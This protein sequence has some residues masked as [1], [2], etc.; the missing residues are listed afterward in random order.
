MLK[1][2]FFN[3]MHV[4]VD[5]IDIFRET[6]PDYDSELPPIKIPIKPGIYDFSNE[7]YHASTGISCSGLKLI[8]KSPLH[9]WHHY[10]NPNKPVEKDNKNLI[11][12]SALHTLVLE[13][14]L[15]NDRFITVPKIDKRTLKGK[16][17]WK[18]YEN[19]KGR[20]SILLE[21]DFEKI[22]N[23][24]SSIQKAPTIDKLIKGAQYEKSLY[25]RDEE[26][27]AL[28]KARPDILHSSLVCDIK[29]TEDASYHAF[30]HSILKYG[31]YMQ[32]AIIQDG[33]KAI[34]D[35]T[36][37]DF[38]FIVVEKEPPFATAIYILG[39]ESIEKGREEYKS[40]LK[41][42]SECT[43]KNEWPSYKPELINLP[44]YIFR[45]DQLNE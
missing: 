39:E 3:G 44:E 1:D 35:K 6:E 5:D 11:I 45:K 23:M 7:N 8:K 21:E 2:T 32:C 25:W 33:C 10:L 26:T 18:I 34:L 24:A 16:E 28:T 31:Y 42:Y 30:Q 38:L 13:P 14:K 41:I 36:I 15:F 27:K 19:A 40:L 17:E 29:T 9:Y 43:S 37:T 4:E 22:Y 12:G 20:R